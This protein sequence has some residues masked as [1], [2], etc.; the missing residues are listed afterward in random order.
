MKTRLSVLVFTLIVSACSTKNAVVQAAKPQA[1]A[2]IKREVLFIEETIR[3]GDVKFINL[4]KVEGLTLTCRGVPQ[5]V[6]HDKDKIVGVVIE[7]YFTEFKPFQC[8]V[9]V[10]EELSSVYTFT[11]VDREF[12]EET[13]R[14][15]PRT[16][17]LSRPDQDR[18]WREQ[19]ILNQIYQ[20]SMPELLIKGPFV[21]P[22]N[23]KITSI[24]GIRRVYNKSKKGQHLGTDFRAPVGVKIPATNRGKV[25]LAR[26]L[27]YT[28]HTVIID[29]GLEIFTVYGHLSKILVKEG[30]IV[31]KN[32]LIALSGNTGRSSG[33]HLHWGVKVQGQY[34]DGL[35]LVDESKKFFLP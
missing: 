7:S 23:S 27:F 20:S 21:R 26:D 24:Y 1:D 2:K 25:V 30:D 17:K 5:T 15:S 35:V 19:Q 4:P 34:V 29:H 10:N 6:S 32:D 16:I 18:A 31:E 8:E 3:P 28:G 13:L 9:K 11:V 33:P 22:L 14:V 12:Q